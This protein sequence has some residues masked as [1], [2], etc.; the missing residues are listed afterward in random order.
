MVEPNYAKVSVV[1]KK[2]GAEHSSI[3][4]A[5]AWK[6]RT[7]GQS[8]LALVEDDDVMLLRYAGC[9]GKGGLFDFGCS[10]RRG[11]MSQQEHELVLEIVGPDSARRAPL[12]SAKPVSKLA[13]QYGEPR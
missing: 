4:L 12:P 13:A 8:T 1:V 5:F 10:G 11:S 3:E 9:I 6:P 7:D 2:D